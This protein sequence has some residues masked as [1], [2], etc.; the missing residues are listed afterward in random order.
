MSNLLSFRHGGGA[1]I[2]KSPQKRPEYYDKGTQSLRCSDCGAVCN[3][4]RNST[5]NPERMTLLMEAFEEQH[6]L[7]KEFA[8]YSRARSEQIYRRG[9][10][11][12][13]TN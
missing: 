10:R 8:S 1:R 5:Y 7:C 4:R 13:F 2:G 6:K 11:A 12:A 3:V 9:M